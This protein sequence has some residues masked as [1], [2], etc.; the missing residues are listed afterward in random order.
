MLLPASAPASWA[1]GSGLQ[2]KYSS[3]VPPKSGLIRF[4]YE[5]EAQIFIARV[6]RDSCGRIRL[7]FFFARLRLAGFETPE[8]IN[9][10]RQDA[11]R[12]LIHSCAVQQAGDGHIW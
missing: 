12:R 10:K 9:G 4:L 2:P 7:K 11:D 6:F 3:E 1:C 5:I 8:L